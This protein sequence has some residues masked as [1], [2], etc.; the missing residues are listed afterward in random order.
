MDD[1]HIE[2]LIEVPFANFQL[3]DQR[4]L[5][6]LRNMHQFF[7]HKSS[8]SSILQI[9]HNCLVLVQFDLID[10]YFYSR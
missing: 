5:S 7:T 8:I 2:C 6:I 9:G 1:F 3:Y 10:T 4:Y